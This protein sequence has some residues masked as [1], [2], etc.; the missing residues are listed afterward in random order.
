MDKE[1]E[2]QAIKK[3]QELKK[4]FEQEDSKPD[5]DESATENNIPWESFRKNM[6]CGG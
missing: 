5:S 6:G 4:K 3:L 1:K 2:K